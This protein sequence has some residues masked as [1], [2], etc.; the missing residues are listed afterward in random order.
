MR[1]VGLFAKTSVRIDVEFMGV[2]GMRTKC[3][4]EEGEEVRDMEG[5]CAS[6]GPGGGGG[7]G[8]G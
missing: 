1:Q 5:H 4:Q 6:G 3:V 2:V 7:G 8:E